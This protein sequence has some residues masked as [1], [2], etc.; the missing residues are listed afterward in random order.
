LGEAGKSVFGCGDDAEDEE[1]S[2][3][4]RHCGTCT[5]KL[6]WMLV[7]IFLIVT[8]LVCFALTL[9]WIQTAAGETQAVSET[10]TEIHRNLSVVS[11]RA[12]N[13][14]LHD[15]VLQDMYVERL[16]V[17]EYISMPYL[18]VELV[19]GAMEQ[20]IVTL[21]DADANLK[22]LWWLQTK[23]P[24]L[25]KRFAWGG[26]PK[27][28]NIYLAD[29]FGFFASYVNECVDPAWPNCSNKWSYGL[30]V[31][32]RDVV[33]GVPAADCPQLCPPSA[34]M[35]PGHLNFFTADARSG[36]P[37]IF[38]SKNEFDPR[39]RT[40]WQP[41]VQAYGDIVWTQIHELSRKRNGK[42][43]HGFAVARAYYQAGE[44][45]M[46]AGSTLSIGHVTDILMRRVTL[47]AKQRPPDSESC[48]FIVD[49]T[50]R[51]IASS[52]G[53][54][55]VLCQEE[56]CEGQQLLWNETSSAMITKTVAS[57]LERFP[58]GLAFVNMSDVHV[59]ETTRYIY[60][61]FRLQS[62]TSN[63][64]TDLPSSVGSGLRWIIV[65]AQPISAYK[66]Q[67]LEEEA[68]S[69]V[70]A[71]TAMIELKGNLDHKEL[72]TL[73]LCGCFLVAGALG[74]GFISWLVSRRLNRIAREMEHVARLDF[75]GLDAFNGTD[76]LSMDGQPTGD[77]RHSHTSKIHEIANISKAF[78][79]MK[80]GLQSFA[81]YMD[82][83]IVQILVQSGQKARLRMAKANAT[84]FFSDI[85]DFTKMAEALEPSALA[86]LLG[87]YLEE[88]S[89]VVME[90]EGIVGEFNGDE[91][92]AW[93]NVPWDLGGRHTLM[94]LSAAMEQ[95]HRLGSLR[96]KWASAGLPEVRVRMGLVSGHVFAGNIGS[97]SRMKYGL[98]GDNVNL[99]SRLE[100]LC[101]RYDVAVL[102]DSK[103]CDEEG[104]RDS[105]FLRTI[106]LVT[107]KGR[108]EPTELCELVACKAHVRGTPLLET[109]S[110]FCCKF[111]EIHELYR[112][113]DFLGAVEAL[114]EYQK[115]WPRDKPA[116]LLREKCTALLRVAPGS[117][118]SAVEHLHEK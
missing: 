8:S 40:W 21:S 58:Q 80:V 55:D 9:L 35:T 44:P 41:A 99:A 106:D 98:V 81:R 69:K 28:E 34:G 10:H 90:Y 60:S 50:G 37:N 100:Q 117:G 114:D 77:R 49:D 94:A 25:E 4:T 118:W 56:A 14:M 7:G 71:Q 45:T 92:M 78:Q 3:P 104:V 85:A 15:L 31:R 110:D 67:I 48:I 65:R 107:V 59:N 39:N 95:Q 108:S 27:L 5:L 84:V 73:V 47:A 76:E 22:Q 88:M 93:W 72:V 64:D 46:V 6:C 30:H 16:A 103:T 70:R 111:A 91:I 109:Y 75:D 53:L 86:G 102:V 23:L 2:R 97:Q 13:A 52:T 61:H 63:F 79:N 115:L 87:E 43:V 51:M 105:F 11:K 113:Q 1:A 36:R 101:K 19:G 96:Q 68:R 74:L 54:P 116:Q 18:A 29:H 57:L 26:I 17:N 42:A 24:S 89:N 32:P 62:G 12:V 20:Q 38:V 82:P 83:Y 112:G 33:P 66:E